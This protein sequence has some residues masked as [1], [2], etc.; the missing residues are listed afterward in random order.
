MT[1]GCLHQI[2]NFSAHPQQWD[3][4]FQQLLDCKVE[5]HDP[6]NAVL[7]FKKKVRMHIDN[8]K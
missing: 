6:K 2:G 5:F 7:F 1:G 3:V 8:S 4:A